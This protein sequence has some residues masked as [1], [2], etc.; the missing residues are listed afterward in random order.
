MKRIVHRTFRF[1]SHYSYIYF[2]AGLSCYLV[3]ASQLDHSTRTVS[4]NSYINVNIVFVCKV[5]SRHQRRRV[6]GSS[7]CAAIAVSWNSDTIWAFLFFTHLSYRCISS[8]TVRTVDSFRRKKLRNPATNR[9]EYRITKGNREKPRQ[10]CRQTS[11]WTSRC[12]HAKDSLRF[13][14]QCEAKKIWHGRQGMLASP[15]SR[16][17]ASLH[18]GAMPPSLVAQRLQ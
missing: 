15:L 6:K 7:P 8:K 14:V 10:R 1:S 12:D 16:V 17:M 2:A 3:Y 4:K 11:Q 5:L 18:L 13:I 9:T